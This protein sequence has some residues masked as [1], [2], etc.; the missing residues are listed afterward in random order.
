MNKINQLKNTQ[1]VSNI[2]MHENKQLHCIAFHILSCT[3][4]WTP[5]IRELYI[6]YTNRLQSLLLP[7]KIIVSCYQLLNSLYHN[8]MKLA[9]ICDN[10]SFG[11][12]FPLLF[13]QAE[14]P[15]PPFK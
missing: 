1:N 13:F 9:G 3:L 2:A 4:L 15:L 5:Q 12:A 7:H 10:L 6:C 8:H 11:K 14:I